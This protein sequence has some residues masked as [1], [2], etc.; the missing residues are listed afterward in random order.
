MKTPPD[1]SNGN[2]RKFCTDEKS[3]TAGR[4]GEGDEQ[5][6]DDHR[7]QDR[8]VEQKDHGGITAR[9]GKGFRG[10]KDVEPMVNQIVPSGI[11][12]G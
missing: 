5:Y 7:Q 8:R 10:G 4:S 11:K 9:G 12:V 1:R 2:S 6:S 3:V